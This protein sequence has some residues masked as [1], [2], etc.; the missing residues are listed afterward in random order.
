MPEL[1]WCV[2]EEGRKKLKGCGNRFIVDCL[3]TYPPT[4]IL[5]KGDQRL[6]DA[7]RDDGLPK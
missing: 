3:Y 6:S 7:S 2:V 5:P 1:S 4:T